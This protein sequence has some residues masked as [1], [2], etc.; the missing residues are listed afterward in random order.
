MRKGGTTNI[1]IGYMGELIPGEINNLV[2][3]HISSK[4]WKKDFNPGN[5]TPKPLLLIIVLLLRD[6]III[7]MPFIKCCDVPSLVLCTLRE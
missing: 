3:G 2:P 4:R 5:V 1:S 6:H 7:K